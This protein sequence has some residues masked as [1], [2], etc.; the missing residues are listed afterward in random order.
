MPCQGHLSIDRIDT[1][2]TLFSDDTRELAAN[3]RGIGIAPQ[4]VP[5][6]KKHVIGGKKSSF[7]MKTNLTLIEQRQS[8]PIYK[9]RDDLIKVSIII[10]NI[11][12]TRTSRERSSVIENII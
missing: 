1:F 5:E 10:L 3:V 12:I 4:E 2:P 7:G 6:W 8:L 9:L 11:V